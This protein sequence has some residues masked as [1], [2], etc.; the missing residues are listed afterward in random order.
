MTG[1]HVVVVVVVSSKKRKWDEVAQLSLLGVVKRA[2]E[3]DLRGG[4]EKKT[5][6]VVM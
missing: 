4:P 6:E 5:R 1:R 3:E 2:W